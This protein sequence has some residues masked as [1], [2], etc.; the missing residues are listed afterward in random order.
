MQ[1]VIYYS[2]AKNSNLAFKLHQGKKD[3]VSE[4]NRVTKAAVDVEASQCINC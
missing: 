4:M 2:V 1:T 3:D